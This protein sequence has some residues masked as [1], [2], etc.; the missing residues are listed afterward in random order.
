M[1]ML[2]RPAADAPLPMHRCTS[3]KNS[4]LPSSCACTQSE[5]GAPADVDLPPKSADSDK[6]S[7]G[8]RL[9]ARPFGWVRARRWSR[10]DGCKICRQ[11]WGRELPTIYSPGC[12]H[13][14]PGL[15]RRVCATPAPA[16][17]GSA[18]TADA[19]HTTSPTRRIGP[20]C[21]ARSRNGQ[22]FHRP[23]AAP[24][25]QPSL[26]ELTGTGGQKEVGQ[27]GRAWRDR[28]RESWRT[29]TEHGRDLPCPST[30]RAV[31]PETLCSHSKW[32]LL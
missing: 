3:V 32:S 16:A 26:V 6:E 9:G 27:A 12:T 8:L 13:G 15:V 31:R 14:W 11:P 19:A 7:R 24:N 2:L 4:D 17:P 21:R 23:L 28:S 5:A 30:R 22:R 18:G 10:F 25:L 20:C 29:K 1:N